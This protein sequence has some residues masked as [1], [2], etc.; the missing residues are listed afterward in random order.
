MKKLCLSI[1]CLF[2]L[3]AMFLTSCANTGPNTSSNLDPSNKAVVDTNTPPETEKDTG[4][5]NIATEFANKRATGN[6]TFED[7]EELI[8]LAREVYATYDTIIVDEETTYNPVD[9]P[10]LTVEKAAEISLDDPQIKDYEKYLTETSHI[11]KA[12]LTLYLP[13]NNIPDPGKPPHT[14]SMADYFFLNLEEKGFDNANEALNKT[15]EDGTQSLDKVANCVYILRGSSF[16]YYN[17][18]T[19]ESTQIL[20]TP[21]EKAITALISDRRI[22]ETKNPDYYI[23]LHGLD[24]Q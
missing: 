12:M 4:V 7:I 20:L 16:L 17:C 8:A 13:E 21:E 9:V 15:L 2:I 3:S 19:D 14:S 11:F 24:T 23:K 6:V 18:E 1:I 5:Y 10:K 22:S